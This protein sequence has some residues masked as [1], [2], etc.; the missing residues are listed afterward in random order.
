MRYLIMIMAL[1]FALPMYADSNEAD[2]YV[3]EAEYY[4]KKAESYRREAQYYLKKA[5]GYE[6]EAA[7]YSKKGKADTARSYRRRA[8]NAMGSYETQMRYASRA[9][10]QAADYLKRA[11]RALER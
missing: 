6:R 11:A 5:E 10:D 3:R 4:Q 8:K 1:V 7:Y 2:R 9:D